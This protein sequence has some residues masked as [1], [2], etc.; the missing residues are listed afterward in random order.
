MDR[1]PTNSSSLGL[2]LEDELETVLFVPLLAGLDE[3][4]LAGDGERRRVF[5]RDREDEPAD[6][7]LAVRP[8]HQGGDGLGGKAAAAEG[9]ERGVAELDSRRVVLAV[10]AGRAVEPGVAERLT[11]LAQDH[12]AHEPLL[13]RRISL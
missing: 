2:E 11:R 4:E 9:R 7:A 5:G 1:E 10:D 6:A 12:R 8:V 13:Q 3:A